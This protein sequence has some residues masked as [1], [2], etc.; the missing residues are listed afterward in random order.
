MTEGPGRWSRVARL[1]EEARQ[2][3]RGEAGA[4]LESACAGDSALEGDVRALLDADE[5][6]DGFLEDSGAD[7]GSLL[8]SDAAPP[9]P[10]GT[11]I[12][13]YRVERALGRGGMGQVYLA[14][15]TRLARPVALKLLH[16]GDT[17]DEKRRERLR[18]EA[19]AAAALRHPNVATV[20]ALEEFPDQ[21]CIVSEY[22]PGR[23]AREVLDAGGP[24]PAAD[25]IDVA[26][27]VARGLDAAHH[28][29]IIHRDLK[30]ENILIGDDRTVKILDFGIARAMQLDPARKRLT[31]TGVLVGT[32][33][34][35][36]PEQVEGH[37]GDARS[38]VFALGT[39]VYELV[40]GVHPFQGRT[41][42]SSAA[43]V[44]TAEPDPPSRV[45]P[46]V[47]PSLDHIV[48]RCLEKEPA[49]RYASAADVASDLAS[50]ARTL[51]DDPRLL[52]PMRA[53][54]DA[55][56]GPGVP[57]RGLWR[58]HQATIVALLA[59]LLVGSWWLAGWL[60]TPWRFTFFA[61]V[62]ALTVADG[63]IRVHLL[64]V[65][66]QAPAS[67]RAQLVR[68]RVWR[69]ALDLAVAF[70]VA[71]AASLALP[72]H[73]LAGILLVGFSAGLAAATWFIEPTTTEAAFPRW[74]EHQLQP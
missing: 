4:Y 73:G 18:F 60:G 13:W 5:R 6:A 64:F 32:P 55:T 43:R 51:A 34:Y 63:T 66:R 47:P 54:L 22:V 52:R 58:A 38:D 26:L 36:A 53:L 14:E 67:V 16:P 40:T 56:P 69:R 9:L 10:A 1:F 48:A 57:A 2:L 50:L 39:V 37:E 31:D 65:E 49:G 35:M 68:T 42:S 46:R 19:R 61:A 27:Q 23:T 59:G 8:M 70:V 30:P 11:M 12:G 44:L 3:P 72:D 7:V 74:R 15:D 29:G 62:L 24:L 20:H 17:A 41:A 21:P 45:N 28:C 25:A 71:L 33:G